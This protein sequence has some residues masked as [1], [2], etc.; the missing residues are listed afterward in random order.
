MCKKYSQKF[1]WFKAAIATFFP[2]NFE[3]RMSAI[4]ILKP[5][6]ICQKYNTTTL[7]DWAKKGSKPTVVKMDQ[8]ITSSGLSTLIIL[9]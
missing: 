7:P 1:V 8:R 5:V 6:M 3:R 2:Y 4:A 9:H